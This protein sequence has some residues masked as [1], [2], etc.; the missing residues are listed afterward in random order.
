MFAYRLIMFLSYLNGSGDIHLLLVDVLFGDIFERDSHVGCIEQQTF[1]FR[2]IRC[3]LISTLSSGEWD[4][5]YQCSFINIQQS[6]G[7]GEGEH[8]VNIPL[9]QNNL[10]TEAW[11]GHRKEY[12]LAAGNIFSAAGNIFCRGEY[13]FGRGEYILPRGIFSRPR[14]IYFAAGNIFSAAGNIVT[15]IS[16]GNIFW[17]AGNIF[18]RGE[19]FLGRGEY[20]YTHFRGEYFLGR[21]E[22]FLRRG[23][24]SR[25]RGIFL[26]FISVENIQ[27]PRVIFDSAGNTLFSRGTFFISFPRGIF[28]SRGDFLFSARRSFTLRSCAARTHMHALRTRCPN[29]TNV[30]EI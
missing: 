3:I 23:I 15:R 20:C 12:F 18:C 14:G 21:G 8:I 27:F 26:H 30:S 6:M 11:E 28:H 13:F 2:T 5:V 24:F 19:Y 22:Y 16:A 10:C 29:V 7:I 1:C 4:V 17:A 9:L 25:P